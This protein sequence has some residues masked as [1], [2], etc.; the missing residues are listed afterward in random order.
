MGCNSAFFVPF[1]DLFLKGVIPMSDMAIFFLVLSVI[2]LIGV[3]VTY[4]TQKRPKAH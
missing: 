2:A 4:Y 3:F 1:A